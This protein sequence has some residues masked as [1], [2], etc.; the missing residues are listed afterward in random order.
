[1]QS[2]SSSLWP[3]S[4]ASPM[5]LIT[6]VGKTHPAQAHHAHP[7]G[8]Q[9]PFPLW[10]AA[11]ETARGLQ[12]VS[13]LGKRK[14]REPAKRGKEHRLHSI[15]SHTPRNMST[16]ILLRLLSLSS[17]RDSWIGACEETKGLCHDGV[18]TEER[19]DCTIRSGCI[20]TGGSTSQNRDRHSAADSES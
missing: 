10:E 13:G 7:K 6:A 9:G 1:M 11:A 17:M 8:P 2:T 3:F 19:R 4:G 16:A 18:G 14:L 15:P 12:S 5:N 20:I